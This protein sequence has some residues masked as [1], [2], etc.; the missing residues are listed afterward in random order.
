MKKQ[1]D[2]QKKLAHPYVLWR[3]IRPCDFRIELQGRIVYN[4]FCDV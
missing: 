2:E 4:C 3:I 1:R